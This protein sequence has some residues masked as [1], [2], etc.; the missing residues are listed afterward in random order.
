MPKKSI[1][2]A[3]FVVLLSIIFGAVLIANFSGVK[4]VHS[5]SQIE[6]NT[7][8][9]ITINPEV[10]SLND[11]FVEISKTVTPTVVY[12]QVKSGPKDNQQQPE[13]NDPFKFFFG[14]DGQMPDP[15]PEMGSGSGVI[16]S[17]DGY[18]VTNNH[19]VRGAGDH[20]IKVVL[21]DKREFDAKVIGLDENTDLAV[22]K[23]EANDLP[24]MSLGNSDNI[25]VG[26]WVLAIG[27]PLGLNYTVTAGII[28][29]LGRNI[30]INGGGYAIENFIQTDAAINP[31]NSG[32][33]LVN[34]QGQLVGINSAIKTNTGYYQGYGF[35]IPVNIVKNVTEE[36]IKSG[37]VVRGYIGVQ[38]QTVDE[39]M[40]KGLGLDKAKGVL[41][42]SVQKGG[43]GDE[44][45]LQAGDV[46]LS[47]DGREVNASN[48]LQV[49]INSKRPGDVAKLTIFR[50]GKTMEKD[51]TLK[52]RQEDSNQ[53]TMNNMQKKDETGNKGVSST[54][55]KTL[56]ISVQD[57]PS[58][59]K[60]KLNISGGVLVTSVDKFSD[61]F[62][63]GVQEGVVIIE[64]NKKKVN[65]SADLESAISDKKSGDSVL[66]KVMDKSGTERIIAVKLQ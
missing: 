27:N 14:P 51:V 64:A 55:I 11:A 16:I 28:S 21:T 19:V 46:I 8:P 53:T 26:E 13:G 30:G 54:T 33:A 57:A 2:A 7:T 66:L 25:Q 39:T 38:I 42:Q 50:D 23:I 20:G 37:K 22:I 12:I 41:V 56:G 47:V 49:I 48:E 9:P 58:S 61:S 31:G 6:F 44:A 45:G 36:L 1:I 40:A 18:I 3:G 15:G 17:R 60:E 35:A 32:G 4:V 43:G 5:D 10:K 63:R 62:L 52:P 29:A 24:V 59:L 65:D 34:V